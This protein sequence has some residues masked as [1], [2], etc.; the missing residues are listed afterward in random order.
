MTV[1]ATEQAAATAGREG[2]ATSEDGKINLKLS[3]PGSD[4]P[5]TNPE[6]LFAAGY[7]ACFGQAIKAMAKE[8]DIAIDADALKVDATVRL[9]KGDDGGFYIDV[10]LDAHVAG[11]EQAD[12]ETLVEKAHE[13]CPYSKATRGNVEV[14]LQANGNALKAAA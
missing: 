4:G 13:I 7:A 10:S 2:Q 11:A 5:G 14:S 9:N 3:P 12:A 8:H 6:Q 1:L